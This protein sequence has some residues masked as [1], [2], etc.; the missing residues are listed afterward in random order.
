LWR[1]FRG[2][3]LSEETQTYPER[4]STSETSTLNLEATPFA[5]PRLKPRVL[6]CGQ[7]LDVFKLRMT[8][9]GPR[10]ISEI[11]GLF[12]YQVEDVLQEGNPA[13]RRLENP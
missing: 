3:I 11:L 13:P 12:R 2:A 7:R 8:D 10:E 6:S 5:T 1:E 4:S 9:I